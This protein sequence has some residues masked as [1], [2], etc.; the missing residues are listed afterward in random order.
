MSL[1]ICDKF[2]WE[3]VGY[4]FMMLFFKPQH[5]QRSFRREHGGLVLKLESEFTKKSGLS[6]QIIKDSLFFIE[7]IVH[8]L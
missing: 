8:L 2:N 7:R 5:S 1:L 3:Y 6:R 4:F